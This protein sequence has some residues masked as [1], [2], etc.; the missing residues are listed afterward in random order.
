[1]KPTSS[2]GQRQSHVGFFVSM[3]VIVALGATAYFALDKYLNGGRPD[4]RRDVN[5]STTG[6]MGAPNN[7]VQQDTTVHSPTDP[8]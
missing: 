3:L 6:T 1:M 8:R 5:R 2:G 7:K 4:D